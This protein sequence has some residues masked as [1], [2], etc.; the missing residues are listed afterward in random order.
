M[1]LLDLCCKDS[2]CKELAFSSLQGSQRVLPVTGHSS[3]CQ[4]A[5]QMCCACGYSLGKI[6]LSLE[7]ILLHAAHPAFPT[8]CS[9]ACRTPCT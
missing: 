5:E 7:C 2:A 9:C 8:C 3:G 1:Q 6:E 4:I